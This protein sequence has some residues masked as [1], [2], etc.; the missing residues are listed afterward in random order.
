MKKIIAS[1]LL[2]SLIALIIPIQN[3]LASDLPDESHPCIL[4]TQDMVDTLRA[5]ITREPYSRWWGT[6]QNML[7]WIINFNFTNAS[8]LEKSRYSKLLA[9]AYVMTGN[10]AYAAKALEGLSLINP[11]GNWGGTSNYE[12]QADPLTFYCETYDMLKGSGYPMGTAETTIRTA[13][14]TKASEFYNNVLITLLYTNNWRAR[15]FAALGIA[16]FTL[17]DNGSAESWHDKAETQMRSMFETYQGVGEGAWAEGPYYL[18]YSARIYLPYMIAFNRMITG[19]DIINETSVREV[20]D[21]SWMTRMPDSRRPNIEDSHLHYFFPGY[22]PPVDDI[23]PEYYQWDFQNAPDIDSLYAENYWIP[24]GVSYYDDTLP[25]QEPDIAPTIFL[26]ESGNMIFRSD[27]NTDAVYMLLIGEQGNA[28]IAGQG[29][30][31][32]DA[33]SFILSA[34]GEYLALDAGYVSWDHRSYVNKAK[35]HSL[36]LIDG[37]GPPAPTSSAAGDADAYLRYFY[38]LGDMQFCEDSTFYQNTEVRRAVLFVDK[39][40]FLIRDKIESSVNHT[41]DWRLHGNGGE[42]SGGTFTLTG[43]LACWARTNASLYAS[44]DANNIVTYSSSADTHSFAWEQVLKHRTYNAQV[45]GTNVDF[46]SIVYPVPAMSPVPEMQ[47]LDF[48]A[49]PAYKLSDGIA[50]SNNT[51]GSYTLTQTVSGFST[52]TSDA[53]FLYCGFQ[54]AEPIRFHISKGSSLSIGGNSYFSSTG[55]IIFALDRLGVQWNGY[56]IA[57]AGAQITL[58]IGTPSQPEILFNGQPVTANYYNGHAIFVISGYGYLQVNI[59]L[60]SP[61]DLGIQYL[62]NSVTLQWEEVPLALSYNIFRSSE[63]YFT[64]SASTLIANTNS[65]TWTDANVTGV[66]YFYK[67]TSVR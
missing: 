37:Q 17:A 65:S 7:T 63:A 38:D 59:A 51:G 24:D 11:S 48:A 60:E 13:I 57:L 9:F 18:M 61:E 64:P 21:W 5:R 33:T 19:T 55:Q 30:D 62:N 67:V 8:E 35:N 54:E 41:Y 3:A 66:K 50:V 36:I 32:P 29:H 34:Y 39:E 40:Y 58:R 10:S 27:W 45:T 31:H 6:V 16:A 23:H 12:A 4:Y 1:V 20:H 15:Y 44:T 47:I 25:A 28:R 26:P 42:T 53:D 52:V 2:L 56:A 46:L 14:A 43:D 22:L 49:G